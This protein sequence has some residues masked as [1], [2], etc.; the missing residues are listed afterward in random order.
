MSELQYWNN[1]KQVPYPKMIFNE[2]VQERCLQKSE[3][4]P[5][6]HLLMMEQRVQKSAVSY[7]AKKSTLYEMW[8]STNRCNMQLDK[9]F[10]YLETILGLI[11]GGEWFYMDPDAENVVP[12]I[13]EKE[14]KVKRVRKRKP[15]I[16]VGGD[17][18]LDIILKNLPNKR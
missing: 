12:P 9:T 7:I 10:T 2:F 1:D 14:E 6:F 11:E 17:G 3:Y 18:L 8:Y 16:K 5:L 13:K 15:T 4:A